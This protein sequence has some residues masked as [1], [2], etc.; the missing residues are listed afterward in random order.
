MIS[1]VAK[2]FTVVVSVSG[3]FLMSGNYM[4]GIVC[5]SMQMLNIFSS[6]DIK[7][8]KETTVNTIIII[9]ELK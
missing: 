4:R 2:S 7:N 5:S 1:V 3:I 8:L 6:E 9:F